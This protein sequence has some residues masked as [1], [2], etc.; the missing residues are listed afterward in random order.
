MLGGNILFL[1]YLFGFI[2]RINFSV[3]RKL[4]AM[5][6]LSKAILQLYFS[7]II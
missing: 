6:I 7:V 3:L 1:A 5:T 2:Y 4:F